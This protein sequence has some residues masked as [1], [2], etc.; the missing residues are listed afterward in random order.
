MWRLATIVLIIIVVSQGALAHA[1]FFGATKQVDGYQIIFMPTPSIPVAGDNSTRLNF[2]V[3]KNGTNILNIH[4]AVIIS[5]RNSG[6][7]VDQIPYRAYE[8]SDII[9][10]YT[11]QRAGE[12][13]IILQTR[14]VG[15]EKYQA[16]PLQASFDINVDSAAM[17]GV[18]LD[19]LMLFY[20]TPAAAVIAGIAIYLQ[21]RKKR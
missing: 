14:I 2:S 4:S 5:E 8:F 7:D 19:E 6:N 11:F 1:H 16:S 13:V 18:P 17:Q 10:P 20:V 3:L 15:D 21:S 12:Y 9:I